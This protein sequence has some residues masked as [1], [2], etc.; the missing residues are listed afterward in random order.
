VAE[1]TT[2]EDQA[3]IVLAAF[4]RA[5]NHADRAGKKLA[6]YT[7]YTEAEVQAS[8]DALA[9]LLTTMY[10]EELASQTISLAFPPEQAVRVLELLTRHRT[11]AKIAKSQAPNRIQ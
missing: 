7:T 4:D 11:T 6:E 2:F 1:K 8:Q 5:R 9:Y 3:R 10:L